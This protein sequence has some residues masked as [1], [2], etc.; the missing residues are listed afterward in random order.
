MEQRSPREIAEG[1]VIGLGGKND[2]ASKYHFANG[3]S[4]YMTDVEDAIEATIKAERDAK[5]AELASLRTH[6]ITVGRVLK[7][8]AS[9][10]CI[11]C[12]ADRRA[13]EVL[14]SLPPDVL[15]EIEK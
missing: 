12:F 11:D 13:D 8:I 1:I 6:L 5:D 4:E 9:G 3:L 15:K 2:L 7:V 14:A 10:D